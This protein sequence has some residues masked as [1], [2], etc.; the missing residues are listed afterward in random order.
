MLSLSYL[1]KKGGE[2][3]MWHSKK[4]IV[5]TVLAVVL[6]SGSIVGV[7]LAANNGDDTQTKAPSEDILGKV[8]AIYQQ[9]TGIA[10]DQEAL[11]A[12]FAQAQSEMQKEREQ[13]RLQDLVE[14]GKITQEQAD[15]Y[16]EWWQSR[17]D[18]PVGFGPGGHGG[19]PGIGRQCAPPPA[20]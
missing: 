16:L 5:V 8:C 3:K 14:Q 19:F 2:T 11:K 9:K 20:E 6:L 13:A 15:K 4:F 10:I 18:V 7:A 1:R 17:P 12:A